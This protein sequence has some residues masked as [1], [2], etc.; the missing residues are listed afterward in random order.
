MQGLLDD[1]LEF[2]T[3]AGRA[4]LKGVSGFI[5]I[6]LSIVVDQFKPGWEESSR[7]V[8]FFT[9]IVLVPITAFLYFAAPWWDD[10]DVVD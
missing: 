3:I 8:K 10:F 6:P 4:I 5:I 9:G 1:I 7:S 2:I